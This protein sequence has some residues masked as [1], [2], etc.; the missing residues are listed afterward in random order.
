MK[1]LFKRRKNTQTPV[2]QKQ[3]VRSSHT[4]L[5]RSPLT[6]V[7]LGQVVPLEVSEQLQKQIRYLCQEIWS[8][9]WSGILFY[10]TQGTFGEEDFVVR[11]HELFLMDIGTSTYTEYDTGDPALIKFLM[12]NPNLLKMNKGHI[13]SHNNMG[14]FFSG[15]D[16]SELVDNCGLHNFYVSL[17]VNNKNEMCAKIAFKATSTVETN[18]I[19]SY[20]DQSGTIRQKIVPEKKEKEGVFTYKCVVKKPDMVGEPF[21]GRFHQIRDGAFKR[22]ESKRLFDSATKDKALQGFDVDARW[23]QNGLFDD[24]KKESIEDRW[25]RWSKEF[26]EEKEGKEKETQKVSV[27]ERAGKIDVKVYT[28]LAKLLKLD[29]KHNGTLKS[30]LDRLEDQFYP[31]Y[32]VPVSNF[33]AEMYTEQVAKRSVEFYMDAFPDDFNLKKFN[34][35]MEQCNE[36]LDTFANEYPGLIHDLTEA[37]NLE[38]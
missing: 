26:K 14:V 18:T 11:A 37:L 13:H 8:D 34:V 35:T 31:P 29:P 10:D 36:I 21:S 16:D 17:I 4:T 19:I 20:R 33:S 3:F 9:E 30:V 1:K 28:M 15:T 25:T 12:A 2:L 7:E 27:V 6:I 32:G 23:R 38:I 24:V 22:A 5:Q